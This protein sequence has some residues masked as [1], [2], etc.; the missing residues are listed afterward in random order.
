MRAIATSVSTD[1]QN[2]TILVYV[3]FSR[4]AVDGGTLGHVPGE[5]FDR[6]GTWS[7]RSIVQDRRGTVRESRATIAIE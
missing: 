4:G 1:G 6:T 7:I 2:R 3:D 5:R